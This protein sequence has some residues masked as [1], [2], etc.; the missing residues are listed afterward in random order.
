MRVR[1]LEY[2][3]GSSLGDYHPSPISR[4]RSQVDDPVCSFDHVEMVL[5]DE[6]GVTGVYQPIEHLNEHP[7]IVQ[8]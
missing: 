8:M 6:N 1:N 5:D 7:D 4:L 3:F 2:G